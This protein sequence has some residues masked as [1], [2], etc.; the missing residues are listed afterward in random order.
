MSLFE[1]VG[2]LAVSITFL[3][4]IFFINVLILSGRG[5]NETLITTILGTA[6]VVILALVLFFIWRVL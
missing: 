1:V 3:T 4:C 6:T 5:K 2:K